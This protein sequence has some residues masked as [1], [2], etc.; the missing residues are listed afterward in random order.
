MR[1]QEGPA[2]RQEREFSLALP[3]VALF[4]MF[5]QR[6][7]RENPRDSSAP[8]S[9]A[10]SLSLPPPLLCSSSSLSIN[11]SRQVRLGDQLMRAA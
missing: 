11:D 10:F 9:L 1:G 6:G 4:A 7:E 5:A 2:L 8:R 3:R